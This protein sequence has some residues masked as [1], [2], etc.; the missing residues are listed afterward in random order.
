MRRRTQ[1][2]E[3]SDGKCGLSDK[4][5]LREKFTALRECVRIEKDIDNQS[6]KSPSEELKTVKM[7]ECRIKVMKSRHQ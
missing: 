6:L 2:L 1:G 4:S 5:L 7:K 3:T